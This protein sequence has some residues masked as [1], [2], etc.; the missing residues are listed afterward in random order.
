MGRLDNGKQWTEIQERADVVANQ[1]VAA[2]QHD[3][4]QIGRIQQ[5]EVVWTNQINKRL[6]PT[7]IFVDGAKIIVIANNKENNRQPAVALISKD[8][9]KSFS[10][11]TLHG[12]YDA[13]YATISKLGVVFLTRRG[14]LKTVNL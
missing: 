14:K 11:K 2:L 9:G 5:Q 12:C 6:Q 13:Q 8:N 1:W 4:L 7:D 10:E 3:A